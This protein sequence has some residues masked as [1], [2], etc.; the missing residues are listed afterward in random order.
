MFRTH[1]LEIELVP[2]CLTRWLPCLPSSSSPEARPSPAVLC[3]TL[4]AMSGHDHQTK[5]SISSESSND[6]ATLAYM[7]ADFSDRDHDPPRP[8]LPNGSYLSS[9][10]SEYAPS[11]RS[12]H[13]TRAS[14]LGSPYDLDQRPP[15]MDDRPHARSEDLNHSAPWPAGDPSSADRMLSQS[16]V[17]PFRSGSRPGTPG[18][19]SNHHHPPASS[20]DHSERSPSRPR[21]A[22][23]DSSLNSDPPTPG[24]S[25]RGG[26]S[27]TTHTSA[28]VA[29]T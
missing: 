21:S 9:T 15:R 12:P 10:R 3:G 4:A 19:S 26:A 13:P 25:Q 29:S 8:V 2:V 5:Q 18:S 6:P 20:S 28:S 27:T 16:P 11:D 24:G 14:T 7:A 22:H 17:A 23:S 1:R